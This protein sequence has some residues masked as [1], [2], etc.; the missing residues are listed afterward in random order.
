M[1]LP[2]DETMDPMPAFDETA[3]PMVHPADSGPVSL[4]TKHAV[5][6]LRE[7]LGDSSQKKSVVFQDLL[8]EK[9]ASKADAT[10]MFFEVLV[11]AT[12]DAVKVDQA[13]KSIGSS[14]K[15]S[16]KEALWG[17]WAEENA[18]GAVSQLSQVL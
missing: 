2:E 18:A 17:S 3:A 14:L 7:Q 16:G 4:G 11:L 10:R 1:Q 8:P 15:I 6:I 5:H 13:S 9:R 12:K